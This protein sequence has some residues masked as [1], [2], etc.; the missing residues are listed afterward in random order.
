MAIALG[1]EVEREIQRL[2]PNSGFANADELVLSA[3]A[4]LERDEIDWDEVQRLHD[5]AA[6][7]VHN[8]RTR[9]VTEEFLQQLRDLVTRPSA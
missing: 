1:P 7:D 5:Q 8:G 3:L 2:L 6:D 4:A 9:P